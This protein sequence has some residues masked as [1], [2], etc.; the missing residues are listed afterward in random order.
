MKAACFE[1]QGVFLEHK[2]VRIMSLTKRLI[3]NLCGLLL[4]PYAVVKWVTEIISETV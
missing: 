2:M 4:K 1:E 3:W